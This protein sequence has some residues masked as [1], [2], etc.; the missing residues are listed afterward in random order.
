MT[1]L[2]V[3]A[4]VLCGVLAGGP[5]ASAQQAGDPTF[6]VNTTGDESDGLCSTVHCSLREAITRANQIAG[7]NRISFNI[8]GSAPYTIRPTSALPTITE[9]ASIEGLPANCS[10]VSTPPIVIDGS[11]A[12]AADGL[13][14]NLATQASGN[15][16]RISGLAINHFDS[17]GRA[18]LHALR[19]SLAARCTLIGTDP[20]GLLGR[21]NYYGMLAEQGSSISLRYGVASAN[22]SHGMLLRTGSSGVVESSFIGTDIGGGAALGNAG[23]GVRAE[24][25]GYFT[26]STST[27]SSNLGDGLLGAKSVTNSKI[28]T[29]ATGTTDLGNA[30]SGVVTSATDNGSFND[31]VISGNGLHGIWLKDNADNNTMRSNKIGTDAAG[32]VKIPNGGVGVL[33]NGAG[34]VIGQPSYR[35]LIS[36]NARGVEIRRDSLSSTGADSNTLQNN[37]IGPGASGSSNL[38]NAAEGVLVATSSNTIGGTSAST[39]NRI[40]F[41]GFAGAADHRSG[42][43]VESGTGNRILSSVFANATLGIDLA[44]S[45]VAPN[46]TGDSDSGVNELQNSP[47]LTDAVSGDGRTTVSGT[48]DSRPNTTYTLELFVSATC[49]SSGF[50]EGNARVFS[51][52]VTTNSAGFASFNQAITPERPQG[53]RIT[54]TATDP[55]GNSSEFSAC[56]QVVTAPSGPNVLFIVTDDQRLDSMVVMP[57]TLSWF[58]DRGTN[59]TNA[60][61]TTPL[62]CPARAS[63]FSGRYAHNHGVLQNENRG[64]LDLNYTLQRY[65]HDAGYSTAIIGKF[66]NYWTLQDNPPDFDRWVL[67]SGLYSPFS[68]ND[69]GVV[70]SVTEEYST[71]HHKDRALEFLRDVTPGQ[72]PWFLYLSF[73]APHGPPKADAQYEN[74]AVPPFQAPPSYFEPDRSDK[75]PRIRQNIGT[76]DQVQTEYPVALRTLLS[77][78]DAVDEIMSELERTGEADNT[79]AVFI[80]DNGYQWGEHGMVTKGKP[81]VESIR[82][83]MFM[84][85]PAALPGNR[86]DD[87]LTANI[88]LVPTVLDA[89]N[90]PSSAPFPLDGRSLLDSTWTRDRMLIEYW[91]VLNQPVGEPTPTFFSYNTTGQQYTEWYEEDTTTQKLWPAAEGGGPVQEYYDLAAD[92]WQLTNLLHDGNPA[93]DPPVGA[94]AAQLTRDRRCMGHGPPSAEPPPCP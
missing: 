22:L 94:L 57:K 37:Y 3:A 38:G 71:T 88:D 74:A 87:R 41:N 45:G 17:P 75:P 42:V 5:V 6:T 61:V 73:A 81:Y 84:R 33:V 76:P 55:Q 9:S 12:G 85:W 1:R 29:N 60:Y 82:I 89:A 58:A 25:T 56:Q 43:L 7:D 59:F 28:G 36:G 90:V 52:A 26:V 93:N 4:C 62:C 10:T 20:S 44:P 54:A 78:D 48:L 86:N 72:R 31:N 11:L 35:N 16:V 70:K 8:P 18:G 27:V 14:V 34:N 50:G 30:G 15:L 39:L 65:L 83:P 32:A 47:T 69:Q 64:T 66:L 63:I 13:S 2:A 49:D 92:P 80:S 68:V 79:L 46:D 53:Q 91:N 67:R 21:P 77:V 19:R 23:G 51:G 24:G 40:A